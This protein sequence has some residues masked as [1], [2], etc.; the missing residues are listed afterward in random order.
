MPIILITCLVLS[1]SVFFYNRKRKHMKIK[2][3]EIFDK[4]KEVNG[5][6][7]DILQLR[8]EECYYEQLYMKYHYKENIMSSVKK[9]YT[10]SNIRKT[11]SLFNKIDKLYVE[12]NKDLRLLD[13]FKEFQKD[14]TKLKTGY[15]NH[16]K[17]SLRTLNRLY[18][19]YGEKDVD[20][21]VV[22]FNKEY[23]IY[24]QKEIGELNTLVKKAK[25]NHKEFEVDKLWERFHIIRNLNNELTVKLDEPQRLEEK[26]EASLSNI[27]QLE[28]DISNKKGS[29]YFKTFNLIKENSVTKDQTNEWN[30]IKRRINTF[31]KNRLL[32]KN[33]IKLSKTLNDIIADMM[34]LCDGISADKVISKVAK[35]A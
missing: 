3:N 1:V 11:E 30:R 4:I 8:K 5:A 14:F 9:R 17:K 27:E 13:N 25:S 29:L 15:R 16:F 18:K 24:K 31:N 21:Y 10:K 12:L 7:S 19:K 22:E 28:E 33:I 6:I 26:F 23:D 35:E 20:K 2:F 32:G 34:D